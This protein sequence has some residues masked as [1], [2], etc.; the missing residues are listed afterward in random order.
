L[1]AQRISQ[2]KVKSRENREENKKE[3]PAARHL[4]QRFTNMLPLKLR[5]VF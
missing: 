4:F 3:M 5:F 2:R 1:S